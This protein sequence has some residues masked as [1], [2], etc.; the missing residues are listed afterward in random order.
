MAC[1]AVGMT[2]LIYGYQKRTLKQNATDEVR[3]FL[4]TIAIVTT[5][6]SLIG[7]LKSFWNGFQN[8]FHVDR[9]KIAIFWLHSRRKCC[10]MQIKKVK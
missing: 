8:I 9:W 4:I 10:E 7:A 1:L 5:I 3:R 2:S 6:L